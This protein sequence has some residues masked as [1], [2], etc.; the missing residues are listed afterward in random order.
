MTQ[1][2][3]ILKD[4]EP[5][6]SYALK[7]LLSLVEQHPDT[8]P[9]L[10][11][12]GFMHQITPVIQTHTGNPSGGVVQSIV[13]IIACITASK[14]VDM[15]MLYY[16][17]LID[18]VT[19]IFVDVATAANDILDAAN[20]N[21]L[22]LP[23]LEIVTNILK[24]LSRAVRRALQAKTSGEPSSQE[25]EDIAE[26]LLQDS[27]PLSDFTG[28][29]I[30]F[31]CHSDPEVRDSSLKCLYLVAELFGGEYE[32]V[33]ADENIDSFAEALGSFDSKQKKQ[34]LR[35]IKRV[36][37]SVEEHAQTLR[38]H[39]GVLLDAIRACK[40]SKGSSPDDVAVQTLAKEIL[41]KVGST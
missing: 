19:A 28:V 36:L 7:L 15:N 34:I 40:D 41:G 11:G 2:P 14:H 30:Q 5:L 13:G 27:R 24:H 39:G 26:R 1:F 32:D 31:L 21:E 3:V 17:G 20:S 37:T 38:D 23:L 16:E 9:T 33:L 35:V 10:V 6:P 25:Y 18:H 4:Q 8:I 22:F 29:L 12:Q